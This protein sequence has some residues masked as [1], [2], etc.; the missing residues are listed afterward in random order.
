MLPKV[1]VIIPVYNVEPY[2]HQC[3]DSVINQTLKEIEIICVDDGSTD[4]S[5]DILKEYA[6]K[7]DRIK[8]ITQKNLYAGVA[9][10]TGLKIAKGRYLSFLDSDDFFELDMLEKM[11]NKAVFDN[12]DIVICAW[13]SYDNTT[14][15]KVKEFK[16]K[17]KYE[18]LSPFKPF[19]IR[20]KLL[21]IC[22]PNPWTKLFNR[23]FFIKNNLQFEDC[24]CCN[25]LT[26]ICL[27]MCLANKI[28][29]LN[30][31]FVHYRIAQTN[32]LTSNRNK[33]FDAV[34]Y[35]LDA[36]EKKLRQLKIYDIFKITFISKAIVSFNH[37]KKEC[38]LEDLE[39]RKTLAKKML[40]NEL[41]FNIYKEKKTE[42]I[43]TTRRH[44]DFF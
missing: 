11:Y 14:N 19:R 9:R 26:C 21:D 17:E 42:N 8:V 33:N 25:D 43:Y 29:I 13:D 34:L 4:A 35:A 2:L 15:R 40:S 31:I 36:L 37:G 6:A 24:I 27:A 1:S 32:S 16:I 18:K 5:L 3:L 38:S 7:D 20:N 23:E 39:Y 12:S 28:S 22:K 30:E 41:Y 44:V 10:N